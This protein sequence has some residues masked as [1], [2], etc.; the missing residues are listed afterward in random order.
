[1]FRKSF[2]FSS[3]IP[4]LLLS[5]FFVTVI[6][7]VSVRAAT[8]I[9]DDNSAYS[10]A[11][12]TSNVT[13]ACNN[14]TA[15]SG[16]TARRNTG[17]IVPVIT[18]SV[19]GLDIL[20]FDFTVNYNPAIIMPQSTPFDTTG[21]LS[22]AM[23]ITVNNNTPGTLVISG[24][25]TTP[26]AGAGTLINLK[27][28]TVGGIGT[29]SAVSF[30]GFT[31]NEGVPCVN[32]TAG[33]VNVISGTISGSV[34]YVNGAIAPDVV[35]TTLNATGSVNT[36]A[37]TNLSGVYTLSG[38]GAGAYTVTPSKPTNQDAN[39][40]SGFDAALIAQHVVN[41]ITLNSTQ[42]TAADVS[43]N[44]VI[45]S[46]DSA[47]VAQ[48]VALIA[49]PGVTGSWRFIPAS[50]TY[51]NAETDQ[52]NQDYNAILMGEVS[53]NWTPP[54]SLIEG[55]I[56][57]QPEKLA[58]E[59][60]IGVTATSKFV[61]PNA[62]FIVPVMVQDTT[63]RGI[64]SYQF[65]LIYNPNTIQPQANE[66]DVAGTVSNGMVVTVNSATPGLLKVV[67]FGTASRVGAGT[68]LNFKFT[69][70]GAPGAVSPLTLQSFMFNEGDPQVSVSNGAVQIT[71]PTAA[72]VSLGGRVTVGSRRG[73]MNARVYLTDANG[74]SR[75]VQ[76]N[77]L[78]FYRFDD[79][80]AG[81]SVTLNVVS[82]KFTFAPQVVNVTEEMTNLHFTVEP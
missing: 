14:V 58:P 21:T 2:K 53:G 27:F 24:F 37:L 17:A 20:S 59:A 5:L 28:N 13:F 51:P 63:G 38:L 57:P 50:R 19:T 30:G 29:N 12:F 9:V 76:T 39:G 46:Y 49:N 56:A 65:D 66:I 18:D 15:Q 64:I 54:A 60:A 61:Q 10:G 52:T 62:N 1:M 72:S 67:I 40:I 7:G 77:S 42:R 41:L 48:Y 69:A 78:G 23:T 81:Q 75:F 47:L 43:A 11:P 8:L 32:T 33:S 4:Q 82:K 16:V 45:T 80:A 71:G 44:G 74:E 68:L 25:G 22:S 26:L 34:T 55:V 6:S 3:I 35:R 36:S 79:V 73:L 70:V 31:F